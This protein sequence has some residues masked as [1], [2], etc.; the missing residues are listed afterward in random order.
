MYDN[1]LIRLADNFADTG[2]TGQRAWGIDYSGE[3]GAP[4]TIILVDQIDGAGNRRW[5]WPTPRGK[6]SKKGS[7]S[8][9]QLTDT[10]F[11]LT[12]GDHSMQVTITTPLKAPPSFDTAEVTVGKIGN[13]HGSFKGPIPRVVA[14]SEQSILAV[15]TIGPGE[16]PAV[17]ADGDDINARVTVGNRTYWFDGQAVRW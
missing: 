13:S 2:I 10:G 8:Q 15:I 4:V 5:Q 6:G 17:S 16:H 7:S 1:N 14:D 12:Q 9:P 11:T 3:S